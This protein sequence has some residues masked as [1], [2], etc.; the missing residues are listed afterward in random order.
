MTG[1]RT[2]RVGDRV[3]ARLSDQDETEGV[4]ARVVGRID[5][6][7]VEVQYDEP[8]TR[9]NVLGVPYVTSCECIHTALLAPADGLW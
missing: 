5:P 3:L 7:F 2:L 1:I 8:Q 4:P 9:T 6:L